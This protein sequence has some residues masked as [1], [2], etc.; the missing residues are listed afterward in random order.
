MSAAFDFDLFTQDS[1][2]VAYLTGETARSA[3]NRTNFNGVTQECP[4]HTSV[5]HPHVSVR[6]HIARVIFLLLEPDKHSKIC[7]VDV[8]FGQKTL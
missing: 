6:P 7:R 8:A 2:S 3:K 1:R 4:P 5:S